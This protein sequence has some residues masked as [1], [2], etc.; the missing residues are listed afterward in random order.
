MESVRLRDLKISPAPPPPLPPPETP[1]ARHGLLKP[2]DAAPP[3]GVHPRTAPSSG[4]RGRGVVCGRRQHRS[5]PV[6]DPASQPPPSASTGRCVRPSHLR[7]GTSGTAGRSPPPARRGL[8]SS[9]SAPP[10]RACRGDPGA[11]RWRSGPAATGR[12]CCS[13][14]PPASPAA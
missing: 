10:T 11:G 1:L 14:A 8:S 9:G 3:L 13:P 5:P 2:S 4:R 12:T 7:R 6:G